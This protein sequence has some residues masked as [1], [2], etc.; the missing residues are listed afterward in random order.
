MEVMRDRDS[1]AS[2]NF[3]FVVFEDQSVA[4]ELI[5]SGAAQVRGTVRPHYHCC[6]Y[7][8]CL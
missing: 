8:V 7:M 3:G 6:S 1:G 5:R 2:R 4:A